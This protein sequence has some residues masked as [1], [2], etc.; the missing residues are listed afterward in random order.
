MSKFS[1]KDNLC[2]TTFSGE[3]IENLLMEVS[4]WLKSEVE[5]AIS[6]KRKVSR[7]ISFYF[8]DLVTNFD[9][10]YGWDITVYHGEIK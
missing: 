1:S 5:V 6:I 9:G 2:S 7:P 4:N 8:V 10:E 3:S